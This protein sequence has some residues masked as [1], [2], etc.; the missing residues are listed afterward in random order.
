MK[1]L[2]AFSIAALLCA[3]AAGADDAAT[4]TSVDDPVALRALAARLKDEAREIRAAAEAAHSRAQTE[5][6][7]KFLV[8]RCHE[9]AGQTFRDE[10]LKADKL[11]NR[12]RAIER[13]LKRREIAEKDAKRAEKEAKQAE[14][15]AEQAGK[16]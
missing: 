7:K 10:K 16:Q 3:A 12:A 15:D 2:A 8:T 4:T 13:E 11:T 5:C 9:E 14:K 6:W 1:R